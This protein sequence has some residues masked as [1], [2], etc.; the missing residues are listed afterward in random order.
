MFLK[1]LENQTTPEQKKLWYEPAMKC[2][3]AYRILVGSTDRP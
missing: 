2:V 3:P 1:T